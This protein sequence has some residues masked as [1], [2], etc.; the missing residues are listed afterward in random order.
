M[1]SPDTTFPCHPGVHA[2]ARS[3]AVHRPLGADELLISAERSV[4]WPDTHHTESSRG[5]FASAV[6]LP[7]GAVTDQVSAR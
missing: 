5:K 6:R 2:D 7:F 3:L 1:A 4:G